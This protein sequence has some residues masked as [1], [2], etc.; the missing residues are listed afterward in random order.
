MTGQYS[1]RTSKIEVKNED[2]SVQC[3][4]CDKWNHVFCANVSSSEYENLKLL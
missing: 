2:E 4:L 3:D 1:C